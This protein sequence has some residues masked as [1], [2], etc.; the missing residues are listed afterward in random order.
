MK[1]LKVLFTVLCVACTTTVWGETIRYQ[2]TIQTSDFNTTSY[3]ANNGTHTSTAVCTTNAAK[4]MEV[5]WTSNQ[6]MQSSSATQWQKN[7]GYI[8]NT[9][10]L[11]TIVSI[12]ITSSAGTFT[13]YYGTSEKPTSNTN[14]SNGFFTIKV[15][16][17]TG[18]TSKIEVVFEIEESGS[19]ETTNYTVQ[20]MVGGAE[21]TEGDPTTEVAS[22]SKVT[23]LPTAPA[24]DRLSCAEKFMGWSTTNIGATPQS[25]APEILF[26][27]AENS[28]NI[29]ANTTFYAVFATK[30]T[31]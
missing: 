7:N 6:V 29:T 20:W 21:Y 27:T 9:T 8:Y 2:F 5:S 11:G 30:Q 17:A 3:A 16:N 10:N 13:T 31:N 23:T 4:T 18:K 12:N 19:T 28:P 25:D 26:T 1:N 14:V 22:G 15:G 24:D